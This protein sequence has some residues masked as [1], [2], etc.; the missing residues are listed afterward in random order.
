MCF[1]RNYSVLISEKF[2]NS[3]DY[4]EGIIIKSKLLTTNWEVLQLIVCKHNKVLVIPLFTIYK[5][6]AFLYNEIINTS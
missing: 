5:R 4:I 6:K 2:K 1:A 3:T